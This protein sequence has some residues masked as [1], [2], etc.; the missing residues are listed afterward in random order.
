MLRTL[1]LL[2]LWL[3]ALAVDAA[4]L[5]CGWLDETGERPDPAVL[6]QATFRDCSGLVTRG[7]R[8]GATWIRLQLPPRQE[9]DWLLRVRPSFLDHVEVHLPSSEGWQVIDIGDRAPLFQRGL[10]APVPNLRLPASAQAQTVYVRLSSSSSLQFHASLLREP[11]LQRFALRQGL[12]LV[13]HLIGM[14]LLLLWALGELL[15]R[16][17]PVLVA[18]LPYQLLS[19]LF[20]PAVLGYGALLWPDRPELAD[21]STSITVMLLT[22][23]ALLFHCSLLHSQRAPRWLLGI[24]LALGLA[25]LPCLGLMLAGAT[26]HALAGNA[27]VALAI[28][29]LFIAAALGLRH[30]PDLPVG[31]LRGVY[32]LHGLTLVWQ[33]SGLLGWLP[34]VEAHLYGSLLQGV[35]TALLV[36][37]LLW[38]RARRLRQREQQALAELGEARQRAALEREQREQSEAFLS[39]LAH[40][41]RTPLSVVSLALARA[42]GDRR[43][44]QLA[45]EAVADMGGLISRCLDVGR[46]DEGA[47]TLRRDPIDLARLLDELCERSGAAGRLQRSLQS[48]EVQADPHWLPVILRNLLDNALRHSPPESP[49]AIRLDE[50]EGGVT[51]RID[52]RI[53]GS[54]PDPQRVFERYYRGPGAMAR[55]GAGLGLYLVKRLVQAMGGRVEWSAADGHASIRLWLPR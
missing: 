27:L 51:L 43:S 53:A 14:S 26:G 15:R 45:R 8:S 36:F 22:P 31:V 16:R 4:S 2:V 17:D 18:Y 9:D 41:L 44:V 39:M 25:W 7:Y 11:E 35:L 13:A 32:A 3:P 49:V 50:G 33:M 28:S 38:L 42:E 1:L 30:S 52:N 5:A 46:L 37:A 24:G 34:G 48:C 20:A 12:W 19:I 23:A 47:T 21:L 6:A 54:A 29:V 55:S 10:P 40:E